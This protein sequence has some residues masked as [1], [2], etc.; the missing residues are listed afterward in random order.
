MSERFDLPPELNVY[1]VMELRDALL[2]WA[3]AQSNTAREH[4]EVSARDVESVDGAGL[5][6]LASLSHMERSWRLVE[7]SDVFAEACR[8]LGLSQWL[9]FCRPA[10]AGGGATS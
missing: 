9:Q 8:T 1:S 2:A 10:L 5:Q 6:L 7:A 4:L 3:T